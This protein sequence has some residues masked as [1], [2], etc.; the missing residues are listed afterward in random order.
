M[1]GPSGAVGL[2]LVAVF[3]SG[4]ATI[5]TG[6]RQEIAFSSQPPSST[7]VLG[8][9]PAEILAKVKD[10]NDA[11]D[12]LVRLFAPLLPADAR[13]FL[14]ALSPDELL[15]FIVAATNPTPPAAEALD[16]VGDVYARAPRILRE[17]VAKSLFV[18]GFGTTPLA[19]ELKKGAEYAAISWAPGRRARLLVVETRFNFVTLLNVFTLGIG[20][21]VDVLTGAMFN[22]APSELRWELA[23]LGVRPGTQGF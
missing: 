3:T 18:Q 17:V 1:N 12:F 20:F 19:L 5:F 14:E 2:V 15:T 11:K 9:T 8:G 13:A 7:V 22:L 10:L 16:A 6:T 21:V 4:C 23:P